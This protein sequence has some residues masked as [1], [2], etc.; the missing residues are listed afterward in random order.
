MS[1][2]QSAVA[3]A[4][5]AVAEPVVQKAARDKKKPKRQP[6][7]HV[8]LWNDDD[9]TYQYVI[10]MMQKL[11]GHPREKGMQ[12]AEEVDTKGKVVVLTTTREH[13][14]LK[15]DQIHAFGK[16]DLIAGCKGSMSATIEPAE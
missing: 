5:P 2:E 16:D 6:P 11:F 8:I 9:H 10:T 4:E 1:E 3:V 7:Y 13:A 15:R 14:E 12:I